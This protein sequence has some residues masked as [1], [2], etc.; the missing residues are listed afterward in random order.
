MATEPG[1]G[2]PSTRLWGIIGPHAGLRYSGE[3]SGKAYAA[4]RRYL[5]GSEAATA[6][7]QP[8]QQQQKSRKFFVLGPCHCKYVEG[9]E[10]SGA[11]AYETPF[12][13]IPVDVDVLTT[14]RARCKA[15][16]VSCGV[17]QQ[18]T[19]EDEHSLEMHIM[20]F[21][22]HIIHFAPS[23]GAA[24]I[25]ST[26]ATLIPLLV[27]DTSE[28]TQRQV[29]EV[30]APYMGCSDCFFIISSDFCHW[31]SR[32]RYTYHFQPKQFP[33]IGD[34][35]IAM[36]KKGMELIEREDFSGWLSYLATTKNTI[37]GRNPISV[38]M[39]GTKG[40][41]H[42]RFVGYSQSNR[43]SSPTDSSVSYASAVIG[44]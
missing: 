36:D 5:Y 6:G 21:L 22:S 26:G 35:I 15:L 17:M 4:L 25:A 33:E 24:T 23:P 28:S 41:C 27:G 13:R 31:G 10:V 43:C 8:Q 32:F 18:Q 9:I 20:P 42:I 34:A 12:G 40:S 19:D 30:L 29:A 44:Y 37:C 2:F 38:A 1:I 3:T 14:I 11:S 7:L 39:L 16:G